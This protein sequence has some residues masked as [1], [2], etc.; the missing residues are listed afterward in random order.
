MF[1]EVPF[2]APSAAS[3]QRPSSSDRVAGR[4]L[5]CHCDQT[6]PFIAMNT[7]SLR[8]SSP[9]PGGMEGSG[10]DRR[11]NGSFEVVNDRSRPS[12]NANKVAARQAA[13]ITPPTIIHRLFLAPPISYSIAIIAAQ[14]GECQMLF[15]ATFV[16]GIRHCRAGL[17]VSLRWRVP[18]SITGHQRLR[19]GCTSRQRQS[20]A[21]ST[22]Q[23]RLPRLTATLP[24][25]ST[26]TES[27]SIHFE[28]NERIPSLPA[29]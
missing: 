15:L 28:S 2:I 26:H 6:D 5:K 22:P 17:K 23:R 16:A 21:L 24:V 27:L 7:E 13:S 10:K 8:T 9:R 19:R 18:N 4:N 3:T 14:P 29:M 25:A 11:G 1:D 20:S 12:V